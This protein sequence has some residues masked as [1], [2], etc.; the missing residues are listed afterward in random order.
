LILGGA[1]SI[2]AGAAA[3][4]AAPPVFHPLLQ[5]DALALAS[6][7]RRRDVSCREVATV[8]LDHIDR[9]NSRVNAIVSRAPRDVVL[10][11]ADL[12]DADLARGVWRGPLHGVPHAVKDLT[13]VAGFPTTQGS[14]LF[15]NDLAATDAP[16]VAKL[17]AAGA[18]FVGKTNTPEFGLGSNTYN[19]VFGTTL[20]AY[21]QSLS[22]GGSTGGGA[23][24]VALRMLAVADGTDH[25]GSLRNP[26]AWNN[27]F[28]LRPTFGRTAGRGGFYTSLSVGGPLARTVPDLA[29]LLSVMSGFDER[30]PL[31]INERPEIFTQGLAR[32]FQNVRVGWLGDLSGAVPFDPGILTMCLDGLRRLQLIGVSVEE[33]RPQFDVEAVWRA[34]R[35]LRA[36]ETGGRLKPLYED[37]AKRALLKSEARFEVEELQRLSADD[38]FEAMEVRAGWFRAVSDLFARFEF[39]AIPSAQTF[40]FRSDLH[41][42]AEVGG[43]SMLTY[44][45]WMKAP[46]LISMAGCPAL[47]VPVGFDFRGRAM[48]VQLVARPGA[49]FACLQLAQAYDLETRWVRRRPPPILNH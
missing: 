19:E 23:V 49:E 15:R 17:R 1:L 42:P 3:V 48:G 7:I 47:N 22:A 11:D 44:H 25:A 9:F 37:P 10:R 6:S 38:I 41:W 28:G 5:L 20:N 40:A 36:W 16:V 35:A 14:P 2:S 8:F 12:R 27:I 26:A 18:V 21:D 46:V 33:A 45:E 29:M 31:S 4:V 32:D 39:L 24:G 43:R 34:W 30:S 13:A